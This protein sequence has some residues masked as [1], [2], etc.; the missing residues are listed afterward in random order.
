MNKLP[1][2]LMAVFVLLPFQLANADGHGGKDP[3]AK[4]VKYR[5]ASFQMI[6]YHFGPLGA[7]V[8]GK[9]PF[10]A[11]IAKANAEAVA[12]LSHF[13]IYGFKTK[14]VTDKSTALPK[15]WDDFTGFEGKMGDFQKAAENLSN[16]TSSVDTM[17]P[18]FL[19]VAKTCKGCHDDYRK[20]KK[21]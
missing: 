15:I 2:L 14:S 16:S 19:A 12:K 21:K 4:E 11:A 17:K 18:A 6:K 10:D 20:K 8:K 13:P 5:K 1:A 9:K 3:A 7:M